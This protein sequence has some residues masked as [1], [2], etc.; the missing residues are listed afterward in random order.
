MRMEVSLDASGKKTGVIRD[1]T[2]R[3]ALELTYIMSIW[4]KHIEE[5]FSAERALGSR[6]LH[7]NE[8][9]DAEKMMERFDNLYWS[10]TEELH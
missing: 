5:R 8:I 7:I 2:E 1:I 9:Q 3:D 10:I 4:L 6:M